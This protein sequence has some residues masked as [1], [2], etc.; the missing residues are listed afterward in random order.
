M[1][2]YENTRARLECAGGYVSKG[3]W[4]WAL[5]F[6]LNLHKNV[7]ENVHNMT[8]LSPMLPFYGSLLQTLKTAG[9]DG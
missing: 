3:W 5:K 6:A 7:L 2:H 1:A 4:G 9:N 8:T